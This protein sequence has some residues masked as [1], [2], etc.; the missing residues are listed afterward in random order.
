MPMRRNLFGTPATDERRI[1]QPTVKG[2]LTVREI[3]ERGIRMQNYNLENDPKLH[4]RQ[5]SG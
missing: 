3:E 1:H 4:Q 2:F 5:G